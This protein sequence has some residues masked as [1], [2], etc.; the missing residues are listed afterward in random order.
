M[1][2]VKSCP[3]AIFEEAS[4]TFTTTEMFVCFEDNTFC[5]WRV[6]DVEDVQVLYS[7]Q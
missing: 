5:N 4:E 3:Q 7:Y 2:Q 6:I 1:M